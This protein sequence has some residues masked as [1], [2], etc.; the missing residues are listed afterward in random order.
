M[1]LKKILKFIYLN[2]IS[3]YLKLVLFTFI[4]KKIKLNDKF[5]KHLLFKG[6]FKVSYKEK[7]IYL[8]SLPTIIENDIFWNRLENSK[9]EPMS[10]KIFH[11]FSSKSNCISD[12]GSNTGI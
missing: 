9:H 12:G 7:N 8:Y 6:F 4:K 5:T 1:I 2:L 10:Y 3:N 11:Y